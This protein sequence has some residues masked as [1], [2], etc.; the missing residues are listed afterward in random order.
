MIIKFMVLNNLIEHGALYKKVHGTNL[1]KSTC[2]VI[3]RDVVN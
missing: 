2:L 1:L 3:K